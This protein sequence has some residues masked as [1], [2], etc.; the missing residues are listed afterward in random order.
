MSQ[1]SGPITVTL[2]I[3]RGTGIALLTGPNTKTVI[4]DILP[5]VM[6]EVDAKMGTV[7]TRGAGTPAPSTTVTLKPGFKGAWDEGGAM[8]G[9]MSLEFE[10]EGLPEGVKLR[11]DGRRRRSLPVADGM[12]HRGPMLLPPAPVIGACI[13]LTGDADGDPQ[14]RNHYARNHGGRYVRMIQPSVTLDPRARHHADIDDRWQGC[15]PSLC[16][17]GEIQARVTIDRCWIPSQAT[18]YFRLINSRAHMTIF[19]YPPRP[20]HSAVPICGP[21]SR[22]WIQNGTPGSPS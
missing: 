22:T 20:V 6:V 19:D 8:G 2:S 14:S 5:G 18:D 1:A 13:H 7:R 15:E 3:A 10:V 12:D 4:G 21:S 16:K 17:K 11:H 9:G